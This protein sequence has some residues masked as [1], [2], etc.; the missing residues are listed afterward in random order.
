MMSNI[1]N[2]HLDRCC[3]PYQ[4][5]GVVNHKG[6]DLRTLSKSLKR[7]FPDVPENARICWECRRKN[8]GSDVNSG[9]P[10]E[11]ENELDEIQLSQDMDCEEISPAI[12]RSEREIE[13]EDMLIDLKEKFASLSTNDPLKLRILTVVPKTWSAN[14]ISEEFGCSW[15]FAKKAKELRVA[16]GIFADTTLKAGKPLPNSTVENV[17][18][19]YSSDE[20]S[21]IMPGK[22]DV[23]SVKNEEGR[24][25]KQK[26]LLLLDLKGLFRLHKETY[27]DFAVSF[28][29][30]AQ[31]R[32]KECVLA[33][34]SGTHSVCVCTIHQ[35]CKLM[36]EAINITKL[37]E[38][39]ESPITN[40]K[41]CLQRITCTNPSENC[42]LCECDKCPRIEDFSQY[43]Q[44][45][46]ESKNIHH[47]QF[48]AWTG[49]DRSTLQTRIVSAEEFVEELSNKLLLLKP[50][51]F[52]S[53]QQSQF[54]KDKKDNLDDGEVLV[55]LDFSENY[56]YIAQDASQAFHFNNTQCTVFPVVYYYKENSEIKHKSLVFLSDSTRHD[57]AAVY[58]IQKMLIPH[59]K[60][61]VDV[62]KIIYFSDGAKQHF[63]NKF[64]MINLIHHEEDFGV[65]A[66]WSVHTTAH[67]KAASDGIGALFKREAAR[68]SLLCQP[69]DA[70]LSADKLVK[71]GENYFSSIKIF[72]YSQ[73]M[74]E[75][76]ERF[77]KRR[78]DKAP[79]VPQILKNHCFIVQNNKKLLIKRY[80]NAITGNTLTY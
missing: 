30:F 4:S 22:K 16:K 72:F 19:F 52:L 12:V 73:K 21:R 76:V 46:L 38:D 3:N 53:K 17:V 67:G 39:S 50:H 61:N 62:K 27:P 75:K 35:N 54:F 9:N 64:Q 2:A 14:K 11:S 40:Y 5:F 23:V 65:K 24:C 6:K 25:L 7:K 8:Y 77:L 57:T 55:V 79:A 13:L 58:T 34:G 20:N 36:L 33:G 60:E 1:N 59:L 42:F 80:S 78:F 71:W 48:S 18:N 66:D 63:K 29:K 41:D 43:V 15:Q 32:P 37:T 47:V 74:H 45:L 10:K 51:S 31:L 68:N 28:S 56:K 26:R 70:I 44:T 69:S 49:T